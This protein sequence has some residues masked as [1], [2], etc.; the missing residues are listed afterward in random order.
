MN[1]TDFM[2]AICICY[3]VRC[4]LDTDRAVLK[5]TKDK[6]SV[7]L[8]TF[9]TTELIAKVSSFQCPLFATVIQG[10]NTCYHPGATTLIY[11]GERLHVWNC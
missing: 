9:L 11:G 1:P 2:H 8:T 4:Y 7:P 10:S 5:D 6:L 3:N